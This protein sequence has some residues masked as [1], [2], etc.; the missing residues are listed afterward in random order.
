MVDSGDTPSSVATF[1]RRNSSV[2]V[3]ERTKLIRCAEL[4]VV[5]E[6]DDGAS[7][8]IRHVHR[9]RRLSPSLRIR[10]SDT[11]TRR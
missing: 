2:L 4:L 11:R 6:Q 1:G 10:E 5:E 9:E 8:L 7:A 3:T